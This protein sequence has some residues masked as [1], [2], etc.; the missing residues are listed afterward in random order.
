MSSDPGGTDFREMN[1]I[2]ALLHKERYSPE[3]AAEILGMQVRSIHTAIHQGQLK[4][5]T[6]GADI[7]HIERADLLEWLRDRA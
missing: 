1:R 3:E 7:V 6:V 5:F 4:A 2:Q